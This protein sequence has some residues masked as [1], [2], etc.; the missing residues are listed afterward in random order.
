MASH[1]SISSIRIASKTENKLLSKGEIEKFCKERIQISV[2]KSIGDFADNALNCRIVLNRMSKE[3]I[4][5]ALQ[6]SFNRNEE[7]HEVKPFPKVSLLF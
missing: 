2:I 1:I 4:Q 6:G 3:Y 7:K 5:N